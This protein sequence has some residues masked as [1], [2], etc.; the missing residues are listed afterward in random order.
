L[1]DL[2]ELG[3]LSRFYATS[4]GKRDRTRLETLALI[5]AEVSEV[6]EEVKR[7]NPVFY[8]DEQTRAPRGEA[9]ELADIVLYVASYCAQFNIDLNE[10]IDIKL[11]YEKNRSDRMAEIMITE[12]KEK[13][14]Q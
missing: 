4:R 3:I 7:F 9:I 10:A 13:D 1:I 14:S 2:N 12:L 8:R 5:H 11:D 6:V